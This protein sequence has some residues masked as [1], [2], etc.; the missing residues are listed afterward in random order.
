MTGS[1]EFSLQRLQYTDGTWAQLEA[2]WKQLC[3]K[4]GE[5]FAEYNV[6]TL[7]MLEDVCARQPQDINQGAYGLLDQTGRYHA[8]CF[9]NLTLQKGYD[10]LVLR[11]L[12]FLLSPHY[13]FE[14]LEI[15]DY[16]SVLA[17]Y[18]VSLVECSN[19]V[20]QSRHLKIHY[21]SPYDR[22]FFAVIAPHLASVGRFA[23]VES[24]G[25]WLSI[26]KK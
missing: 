12:N 18:F 10:G 11:V 26:T 14:D 6:G 19:S 3:E 17:G 24:R 8:V 4:F 16:S 9:L 25:M 20:L 21:R 2:Q 23:A 15:E 1:L 22:Q 13:D 5:D 7:R